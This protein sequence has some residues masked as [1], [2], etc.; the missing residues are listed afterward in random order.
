MATAN[1]VVVDTAPLALLVRSS[2]ASADAVAR[3][4]LALAKAVVDDSKPAA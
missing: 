2:G 1:G 3:L 4:A